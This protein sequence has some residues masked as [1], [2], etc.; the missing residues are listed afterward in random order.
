MKNAITV[1]DQGLIDH[2]DSMLESDAA[3]FDVDRDYIYDLNQMAKDLIEINEELTK[4]E[5][6][7]RS[8]LG[9]CANHLLL[10]L[11]VDD[12][13]DEED[14]HSIH[15]KANEFLIEIDKLLKD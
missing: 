2:F 1:I 14:K 13:E 5:R 4:R 12:I 8:K 10:I 7:Y 3:E 9:L 11:G 6:R 15:A